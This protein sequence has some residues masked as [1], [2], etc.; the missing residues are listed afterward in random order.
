MN[1]YEAFRMVGII[2]MAIPVAIGVA[3]F[4]LD[5]IRALYRIAIQRPWVGLLFIFFIL[6][7][8][9]FVISTFCF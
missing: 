5:I 3:A 9:L 6:G 4:I 2:L 1:C 8:I 7:A